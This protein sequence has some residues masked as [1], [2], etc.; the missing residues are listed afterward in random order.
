MSCLDDIESL[1]SITSDLPPPP[2]RKKPTSPTPDLPSINE[3]LGKLSSHF[4][5]DII[6]FF[7]FQPYLI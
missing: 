7:G 4:F 5:L 1:S 6:F 3:R 2:H